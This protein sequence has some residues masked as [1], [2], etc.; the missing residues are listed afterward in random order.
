MYKHAKIL[1]NAVASEKMAKSAEGNK[2]AALWQLTTSRAHVTGM[3][4]MMIEWMN[5]VS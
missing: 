4:V 2:F 1:W 3:L 5:D